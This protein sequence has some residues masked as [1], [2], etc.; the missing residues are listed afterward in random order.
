[1]RVHRVIRYVEWIRN[2]VT[3]EQIIFM[4]QENGYDDMAI[5]K[6]IEI[7]H[8][9]LDPNQLVRVVGFRNLNRDNVCQACTVKKE[10]DGCLHPPKNGFTD[11]DETL[12]YVYDLY[13]SIFPKKVRELMEIRMQWLP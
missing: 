1:M 2:G 13:P 9:M 7:Y 3:P 5:E 12:A 4:L 8:K 10:L 11:L 6:G